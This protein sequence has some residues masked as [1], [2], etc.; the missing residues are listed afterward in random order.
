MRKK[1]WDR[2][3]FLKKKRGKNA[4]EKILKKKHL[5]SKRGAL[6]KYMK[7]CKKA[8]KK[9]ELLAELF[10]GRLFLPFFFLHPYRMKNQSE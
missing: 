6:L 3:I 1:Y 7:K 5:K 8:S 2:K 9:N 4:L 10:C